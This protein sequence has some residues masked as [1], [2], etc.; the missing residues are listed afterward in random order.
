LSFDNR[1]GVPGVDYE[2]FFLD[3]LEVVDQVV[4]AVARRHRLSADEADELGASI[5]LKLIDR[6]YEV[7]RRFERRCNLRTYLT[8]VVVRFFLDQRNA[9][10]G[11]WRPSVEARHLGPV[12]ML[13]ERLVTRDGYSHDEAIEILK[14]NHLVEEPREELARMC[15]RFPTRTA[16]RI[17][18][19]S[20]LDALPSSAS[21]EE[22]F[23]TTARTAQASMV[24]AA[25]TAALAALGTQDRLILTLRFRDQVQV[26]KIA[27][28]LRLDQ[29]QLYRR[30]E[31]VFKVL[32]RALEAQGVSRED[33]AGL[34]GD[35][36]VAMTPMLEAK[37]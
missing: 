13:L 37:E 1:P 23:E 27:R 10:W 34:V 20:N 31:Q 26:S 3:N 28:L 17:L 8:A 9:R 7:L 24:A 19:D 35:R 36:G 12:A 21:A 33:I 5:R 11:K 22:A 25:L 2:R 29:K 30:Q 6:D 15:E 16:R 14:T 4:R 32:R 18:D